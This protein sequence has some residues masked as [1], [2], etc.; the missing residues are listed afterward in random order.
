[1]ELTSDRKASEGGPAITLTPQTDARLRAAATRTGEDA[2]GLADGL[3]AEALTDYEETL[4]GIE[5]GLDAARAGDEMDF[6]AFV[7]LRR[8]RRQQAA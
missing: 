5:R 3:L 8:A 4:E 2:A 1:M 7:A 6:E